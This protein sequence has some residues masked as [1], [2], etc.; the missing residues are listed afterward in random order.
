MNIKVLNHGKSLG[1]RLPLVCSRTQKFAD[2]S[3][4]AD[5]QVSCIRLRIPE[6]SIN[7]NLWTNFM[8]GEGNQ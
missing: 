2:Q 4:S 5:Y 7:R 1:L 3:E 8:S 6:G